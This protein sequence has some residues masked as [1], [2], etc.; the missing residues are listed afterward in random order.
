MIKQ[1]VDVGARDWSNIFND[2]NRKTSAAVNY[3]LSL[4]HR[5]SLPLLAF[6]AAARKR[7]CGKS[8]NKI[9]ERRKRITNSFY[10]IVE[11]A[12]MESNR[13]VEVFR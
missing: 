5:G 2:T 8:G 3:S 12:D 10:V 11:F 13:L 6:H 7:Q 9:I 1:A 4:G